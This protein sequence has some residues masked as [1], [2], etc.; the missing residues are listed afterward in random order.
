M[1]TQFTGKRVPPRAA[2]P[3]RFHYF[4]ELGL[5]AHP[6]PDFKLEILKTLE[7]SHV[8]GWFPWGFLPAPDCLI[9][10]SVPDVCKD[11]D[12]DVLVDALKP[13]GTFKKIGK[14]FRREDSTVGLLQIGEDVDC[15]RIPREVRLAGGVWRVI[16]KPATKEVEFRERLTQFLEEEGR[17]LEDVARIIERSTPHPPQPA[18]KPKPK[19]PRVRRRVPQMVTPPPRL[20]V[21]TYDSSNA[22]DSDLS[23]FETSRPA[24]GRGRR[25][26]V[27]YLGS[28]YLG[29][30]VESGDDEELVDAYLRRGEQPVGPLA[31][32][33]RRLAV[34]VPTVEDNPGPQ[35][36]KSDR[37]RE[38]VGQVSWGKLRR[39]VKGWAPS[40]GP[41]GSEAQLAAAPV[42]RAEAPADE[43][44]SGGDNAAEGICGDDNVGNA[45]DVHGPV[46]PPR[47]QWRPKI[48]WASFRR[49]Q[50]RKEVVDIPAD[51]GADIQRAEAPAGQV[52]E[53]A[54]N[55]RAE[56]IVLQE[57]E[58]GDNQ[59]A[60]VMV[61]Q[62]AEVDNQRAEAPA[63]EAETEGNQRAE[64]SQEAEVEDNQ[65]AEASDS[66]RAEVV[67]V[68]RGDAA[69]NQRAEASAAQQVVALVS[70]RP[71]AQA[72]QREEAVVLQRA[73]DP[74]IWRVEAPLVEGAGAAHEGLEAPAVHEAAPGGA[75]ATPVARAR[76]QVKTVRFQTPGRFSW[77][78]KRG[79]ALWASPRLPA[80]PKREPRARDASSIRALRASARAEAGPGELEEQL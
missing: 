26:P 49:R 43:G 56:A 33:R 60:E 64:A 3:P 18:A 54:D 61:A 73:E 31:P 70:Q 44:A 41:S 2:P 20:V 45:P 32:L 78:R 27:S 48:N 80:L 62:E 1:A 5:R 39:K 10:W 75:R 55:Q 35:L 4:V 11:V 57:A 59:M 30:D 53:A 16:S 37:W 71:E 42:E 13:V 63:V 28:K 65:R 9:L 52:A 7:K 15:L 68:Q 17:T 21:G 29:S 66:Q 46:D 36:T 74:H 50:G 72:S 34:P 6:L 40:T 22:S 76:K 24:G 69:D 8:G 67:A 47:R 79:R 38:C 12:L 19:A 14:V 51:Q 23:D 58:A 77:F 25:M